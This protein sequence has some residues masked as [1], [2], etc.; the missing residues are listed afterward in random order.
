VVVNHRLAPFGYL[1]AERTLQRVIH[2]LSPTAD[3]SGP[4]FYHSF[5]LRS[6]LALSF[7]LAE[8]RLS[9]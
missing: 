4:L 2:A 3:R 5:L 9:V 7:E 8:S 1:V 6:A